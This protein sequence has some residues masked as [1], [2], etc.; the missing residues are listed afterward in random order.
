M[1]SNLL[2]DIHL[3]RYD[4]RSHNIY[5]VVGRIFDGTEESFDLEIFPDGNWEFNQ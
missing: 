2:W 1:T 3:F 4:R 5:I